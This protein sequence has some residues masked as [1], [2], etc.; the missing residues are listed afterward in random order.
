[1]FK[2][3]GVYTTP[4]VADPAWI[5]PVFIYDAAG[6]REQT[7]AKELLQT[8]IDLHY[9]LGVQQGKSE[10]SRRAAKYLVTL[11]WS[12]EQMREFFFFAPEK[13][14][15]I[16]PYDVAE[17]LNEMKP[18]NSPAEFLEAGLVRIKGVLYQQTTEVPQKGNKIV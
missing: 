11:G 8:A 6:N 15:K 1:M 18:S 14:T 7:D 13:G 2:S 16:H 12:E 5:A 3:F 17:M 10:E 4:H 9:A